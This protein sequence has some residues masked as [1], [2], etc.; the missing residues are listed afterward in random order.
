VYNDERWSVG[1][2]GISGD[3]E[4]ELSKTIDRD[5]DF[6]SAR[7][8][9]AEKLGL[10]EFEEPR[11]WTW[12]HREDGMTMQLVPTELHNNMPHTGGVSIAKDPS[13]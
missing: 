13:Y 7:Q 9:M 1:T 3:V 4:I 10:N 11:H 12:H 6:S 2:R 5:K 8:A